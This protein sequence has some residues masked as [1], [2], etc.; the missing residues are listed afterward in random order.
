MSYQKLFE[1]GCIGGVEIRN[2]VAM[3]AMGN[4]L[5]TWDGEASP[6][7][8]RFYEDRAKGGCGLIF[9]E[10]T[11]VDENSGACNPNQLCIATRKH[12]RSVQR[13]AECVHR[14]GGKIFVQLHHGGREAPPALNDGKQ[15]MG[16]SAILNKVNGLVSTEMTKEDIDDIVGKFVAAAANCK[17][18]GIDGVELHGAHGYLLG[19]FISPYTNKRTD[20]YGGSVENCCRIVTDIIHGIRQTCGNYPICVRING[21]DFV[22]G[23]ITLD[24]AVQVAQVLEAAGADAINVSCAVYETVPNMIEPNYYEE[25]WR[26]NLAKTVKAHVHVPV[27]AVNTIKFPATAEKLLK[28]GVSDFVGVSRGQMADPEWVN[29]TKAGREDLI[30]K[31]MGCMQCNKS[32]VIDGYLSCAAN[33]VTGRGT[34]YNDEYL[35]RS[36]EGKNVVVIGGGP[37]GMQAAITLAKRGFSVDLLEEKDYLGGMAYL[38]TVPPH[39]TMVAEF[40][41]TLTAEMK[42][43]KVNVQLNTKAD[44]D[45][46]KALNPYAVVVANGGTEIVP[47]V[48]SL[49][50][51]HV[52]T[53]EDTLLKK[54]TFS[55]KHVAVI[56]GGMVGLET[57]H[58][59]CQENKVTIVEMTNTPGATMYPT[60]RNKLMSILDEDGV[61]VR[62]NRALSAVKDGTIVMDCTDAAEPTQ[63][64]MDVD[65]VVIAVGRKPNLD[66][67][68]AMEAT[69]DK[70]VMAGDCIAGG[71]ILE[72][73]RTGLDNVWFL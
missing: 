53:M 37:A 1:K 63:E 50:S 51:S 46:V 58:Y 61:E 16:P 32:V 23:G 34:M 59:L 28:E 20:D 29:K 44:L 64:T 15:P 36:G 19:S 70:V 22:E 66:L 39:K 62:L 12:V 42:E 43:Y 72:A 54:V 65:E 2:R 48:D 33:P 8:I 31:C 5:A 41:K 30:R 21:D 14:H 47:K 45:T 35:I 13:M 60:V 68:H 38:A 3:T 71:S 57:A 55:G 9:T 6:E 26:K 25:G 24:Y 10:F 69:F 40:I 17:K 52:H 4:G 49:D 11:R 56:G 27:I 7:L 18:A 67:F 73:T